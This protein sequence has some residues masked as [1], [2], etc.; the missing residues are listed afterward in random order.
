MNVLPG[1]FWLCWFGIAILFHE[2]GH[3]FVAYKLGYETKIYWFKTVVYDVKERDDIKIVFGGVMGG[4]LVV[5]LY[6][7]GSHIFLGL[8]MALVYIAGCRKEIWMLINSQKK[9]VDE[10]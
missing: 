1:L 6:S 4:F 5:L 3:A 8:G 10:Q 9:G 2:L 7:L